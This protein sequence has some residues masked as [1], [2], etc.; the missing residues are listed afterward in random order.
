MEKRNRTI[1]AIAA[2]LLAV[3]ALHFLTTVHKP[4]Y[5][6][7]YDR[8][9]YI[10]IIFAAFSFGLRGGAAIATVSAALFFIHLTTQ[11]G[12]HEPVEML[13]RY[14]EIA[15][16]LVVGV[17]T[18]ALSDMEKKQR[19]QTESAYEK[20]S[21]SFEKAKEAARLAA[22]GRVS[23]GV[24]HE[25]RNPLG[26]IK[27]AVEIISA[28]YNPSHPKYR[29]VEIINK[30]ISRMELIVGEFLDFSKPK[31][32]EPAP[33]NL[34]NLLRSV[35][36][37]NSKNLSKKSISLTTNFDDSIPVTYLDS[38]Q[39]KQVFLNVILNCIEN[40][41]E[42][43]SVEVTSRLAG[44]EAEITIADTGPGIDPE[45]A[46]LLFEPFYTTRPNGTG[47]GLAIS[48]QIV[49]R[50]GGIISIKNRTDKKGAIVTVRL[51][52]RKG[53]ENGTDN[54]AR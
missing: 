38:N 53:D 36:D 16:Y 34:N 19:I 32:P 18:G 9:Y 40:M 10:P 7:I 30:E 22:I 23:A 54:S 43:G 27:G 33:D 41:P 2:A 35:L 39:I 17:V 52:V 6:D 42:G 50:H 13:S 4:L 12:M 28:D 14:L 45:K 5:H 29:F 24:A 37:L 49:E 46:D 15:M 26:G 31:P 8:L 25:I 3:T 48:K 51:P 47:L 1:A 20:L 21:D 44:G 11:W